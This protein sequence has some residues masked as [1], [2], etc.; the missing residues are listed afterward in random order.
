LQKHRKKE[1]EKEKK[2]QARVILQLEPQLI[3]DLDQ[4]HVFNK[5]SDASFAI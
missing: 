5:K 1:K 3:F 2:K 4:F